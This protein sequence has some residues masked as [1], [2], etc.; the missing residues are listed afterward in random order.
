MTSLL[1][2]PWQNDAW[3]P[4]WHQW[5]I[6][7]IMFTIPQSLKQK[8]KELQDFVLRKESPG[9]G[10]HGRAEGQLLR[11]GWGVWSG[12]AFRELRVQTSAHSPIPRP[13]PWVALS[14]YL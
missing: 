2:L 11:A 3:V 8:A 6:Y 12:A 7:A 13:L 4:C 14:P 10:C 5:C 1:P 9:R